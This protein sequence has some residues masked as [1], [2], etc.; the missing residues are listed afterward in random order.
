MKISRLLTQT[1][2]DPPADSEVDSQRLL[3]RAG[4]L[5]PLGAGIFTYLHLAKRSLDKI[6]RLM[7]EEMDAIGGQEILMPV[8]RPADLW[9]ESGRRDDGGPEMS[10]LKDQSGHDLVLAMSHEEVVADLARRELRS[11]RQLPQLLYHIQTQW[12][13]DPHPR[14]GL[15]RAREFTRLDSYSLDADDDGLDRQYRAHLQAYSHIF[16]RCGLP[17]IA[18][19]AEGGWMGASPAHEFIYPASIGEDTIL[20]CGECGYSANR[21]VARLGRGPALSELPKPLAKVA[22]P[23]A[24][25]IEELAA[26]LEIPPSRTAKAVF[27]IATGAQGEPEG[28]RFVFVI[29]RGDMSLSETKLAHAIRARALR[30]ATVKEIRAVGAVPGYASAIGV[31][32]ALIVVDAIAAESPNLVAGANEEG[33]HFL[34]VN[35]GRDYRADVVADIAAAEHGSPCPE[36]G[37][38][39]SAQQGVKVGS[40]SRLGTGSTARL[41]CTFLDAQGSLRPVLMGSY[42]MGVGRLLACIAEEHHDSL[43]LCWPI[44][45]A[46]FS[47]HLVVLQDASG[48]PSEVAETLYEDLRANSVEVLYDDRADSPG[49]KFTD[50]DLIG[51]PIRLTV[52]KRALAQGGVELRLRATGQTELVPA[53]CLVS[54]VLELQTSLRRALAGEAAQVSG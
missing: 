49:V 33:F 21:Q 5:R 4:F 39:L 11:Y 29:V 20:R 22:T 36:C 16:R 52:A 53:N 3:V 40:L 34:N 24:S 25:T 54:R 2:R 28:E 12:R 1:L 47:V 41:G 30:P 38:P 6:E 27:L 35:L 50:A 37:A 14:A 48:K 9:K 19:Q 32:E 18:V 23:E 10:R 45:V 51:V 46:P 31:S 26:L 44:S 8:I 17:V 7:R 13:D 43:G 15:I 42:G